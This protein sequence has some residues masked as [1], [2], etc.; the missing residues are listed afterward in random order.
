MTRLADEAFSTKDVRISKFKA[1]QL[2][3]YQE[4]LI[5][6][7]CLKHEPNELFFNYRLTV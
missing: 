1:R 3:G 4:L 5:L 7:F 2:E 6:A